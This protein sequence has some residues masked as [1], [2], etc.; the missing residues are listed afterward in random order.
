M[1]GNSVT[2]AK[3]TPN[4]PHLMI[5]CADD[6]GMRRDIDEAI[7][8]LCR[9]GR[10]T[11]VSCMVA[12]KRCDSGTMAELVGTRAQMERATDSSAS[13]GPPVRPQIGLHL[14]FTYEPAEMEPLRVGLLR[15]GLYRPRLPEFGELLRRSLTRRLNLSEVRVDIGTQYELFVQ[16]CG[17]P[18]DFIDGHLHSHQLPG[19]REALI[20]F[21][22]SLPTEQ[23]PYIRNTAMPLRELRKRDLPWL[24]AAGIGFFGRRMAQALEAAGLKTNDRFAGIYDFD[25]GEAYERYFKSFAAAAG[26]NGILVVHPGKTDVWRLREFETLK[27][28]RSATESAGVPMRHAS[29]GTD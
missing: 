18:P 9:D 1:E 17:S 7:L 12:L 8:E 14:T 26:P 29:K 2:P 19:I 5:I 27:G 25:K 24:K 11:A 15:V 4:L 28:W 22:L 13:I 6:Y 20:E 16:K 23:R 3:A 21:V 10:L